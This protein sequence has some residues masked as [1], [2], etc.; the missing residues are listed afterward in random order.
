MNAIVNQVKQI[1]GSSVEKTT[2]RPDNVI[3]MDE[4]GRRVKGIEM[5]G[6]Y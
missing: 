3:G 5:N 2:N 1:R 6:C 4:G